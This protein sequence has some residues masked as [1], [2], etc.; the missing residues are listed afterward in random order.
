MPRC[1]TA[2][3][4]QTYA[5]ISITVLD[6][7]ST[8]AIRKVMQRYS[9]VSFVANAANVGFGA[10]HNE[11]IRRTR[12]KS[13]DYYLAV[14][15]DAVLDA[16]YIQRLLTSCENHHADW[17]VGKLYKSM[18]AKTLYS[19]G[20]ALLR[21]GYAFNIGYNQMDSGQYDDGKE[22]F[23]APGAAALYRG[24]LIH[25][26]SRG[27]NFFD[28]ALFV[29][30]EDV[31][32]DWRAHLAHKHCWYESTAIA[33]HAGGIPSPVFI[34]EALSNRFLSVI[35]NASLAD[36]IF[37]N[38]PIV[39]AHILFRLVMTPKVGFAIIHKVSSQMPDMLRQ[40]KKLVVTGSDMSLWF[41]KAMAEKSGQPRR[42]AQRFIA[43]KTQW[44]G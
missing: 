36:L 12:L 17:G 30:Y 15:P 1:L 37:I 22:I 2:L 20:H 4:G 33:E 41:Q 7:R 6:N 29:Y 40:R 32:I 10:G 44:F 38:I 24:S 39:A 8:D 42:F 23:G 18:H 31:D 11:I 14:N 25:S 21:D 35:K 28:P 9:A 26:L 3:F 5:P 27:H 19:V 34:S 13:R 16:Q 43:F